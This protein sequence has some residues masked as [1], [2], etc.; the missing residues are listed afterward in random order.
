MVRTLRERRAQETR[1][2]VL[3]AAFR[4]FANKGY[5]QTS[6]DAIISEAGLSKGAVYHHFASKEALFKALLEDRQR[7]CAEQ[8][9]DAVGTAGTRREAIERLVSSGFEFS[10]TDPDWV[11]LYFEFCLQAMRDGLACDV[12]AASLGQCREIIAGMLKSGQEGR[13]VHRDLDVDAAALLLIGLFDGIFLQRGVD[14]EAV[15]LKRL[16]GPTADLIERFISAEGDHDAAD[17][18]ARAA[19]SLEKKR[20]NKDKEIE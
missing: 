18:I 13:A 16:A 15:D 7:R 19:D 8:L 6:V 10:A 2:M 14:P 11:R 20:A 5:G 4:L 3:D 12:V 1:Q 9:A 17:E